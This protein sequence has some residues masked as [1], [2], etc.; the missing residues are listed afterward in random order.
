MNVVGLFGLVEAATARA[1]GGAVKRSSFVN[2]GLESLQIQNDIHT[3]IL[4]SKLLG[5]EAKFPTL[6]TG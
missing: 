4:I 5:D 1:A 6:V 3:I 2:I